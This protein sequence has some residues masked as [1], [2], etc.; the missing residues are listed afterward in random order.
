MSVTDE[1]AAAQSGGV[2]EGSPGRPHEY[3]D[4]Q[5]YL[6]Q[7]VRA[8]REVTPSWMWP[9][10]DL[11]ELPDPPVDVHVLPPP[12]KYRQLHAWFAAQSEYEVQISIAEVAELI[13]GELPA[14]I[15]EL[16]HGR[17]PPRSHEI[18]WVNNPRKAHC[19]AWVNAGYLAAGAGRFVRESLPRDTRAE[20]VGRRAGWL[21]HAGVCATRCPVV[22]YRGEPAGVYI[23]R[24]RE[25]GLFKVGVGRS[26]ED[27]AA[28]QRTR[29][30]ETELVQ[31]ISVNST[32]CA[33]GVEA[34]VLNLTEPW[35][36]IGNPW[37]AGG[38]RTEMWSDTGA[39]P[40]LVEIAN[41]I[42][43]SM[44]MN[45]IPLADSC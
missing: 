16:L 21:E 45:D 5:E 4:W 23:S 31:V 39:L 40:N 11:L 32:S 26:P 29:S 22:R 2:C 33:K 34:V 18:W 10:V 1:T 27:R 20:V 17:R 28:A 7:R 38:G 8:C 36:I 30:G 15:D 6:R 19:R 44:M 43:P 12:A 14:R 25:Y 41:R 42:N 9:D 3:E 13:T 24:S 35:R 37:H